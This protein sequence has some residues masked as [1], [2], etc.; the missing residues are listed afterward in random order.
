M[1]KETCRPACRC[2]FW[3]YPSPSSWESNRT[4]DCLGQWLLPVG[5]GSVAKPEPTATGLAASASVCPSIIFCLFFFLFPPFFPFFP[6]SPFF[7]FF[8]FEVPA[9]IYLQSTDRQIDIESLFR[10]PRSE[11]SSTPPPSPP[12][13]CG[14]DMHACRPLCTASASWRLKTQFNVFS[15]IPAG[16]VDST[17][18]SI[19]LWL[20][21]PRPSPSQY[22]PS[23]AQPNVH[24]R[25][26]TV[27]RILK[28]G[29]ESQCCWWWWMRAGLAG[30]GSPHGP[31]PK[32]RI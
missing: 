18:T 8:P 19:H 30:C 26:E 2:I 25:W 15:N 12:P 27:N 4:T 24:G 5:G 16:G 32:Q 3:F 9:D 28:P 21:H 20:V 31:L 29:F 17:H 14:V 22:R 1:K 13:H 11:F 7:F 23:P 10:L 6:F